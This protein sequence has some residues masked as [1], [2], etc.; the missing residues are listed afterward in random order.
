MN[1]L[2]TSLWESLSIHVV[3]FSVRSL[4][5]THVA[6][7]AVVSLRLCTVFLLYV[8]LA[9]A[10]MYGIN[11][12]LVSGYVFSISF[13]CSSEPSMRARRQI[14]RRVDGIQSRETDQYYHDI[15]E[16]LRY[17]TLSCAG[18]G[19][20]DVVAYPCKYVGQFPHFGRQCEC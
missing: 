15:C 17:L 14:L 19:W 3:A 12:V 11:T 6:V 7:N 20:M 13:S 8:P 5:C 10:C 1:R 4:F 9:S 18:V 16:F 2:M